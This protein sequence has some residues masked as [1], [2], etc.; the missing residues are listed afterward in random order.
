MAASDTRG[1]G[2][3]APFSINW[4]NALTGSTIASQCL[5]NTISCGQTPLASSEG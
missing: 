2:M 5:Q 1:P 4:S 3:S